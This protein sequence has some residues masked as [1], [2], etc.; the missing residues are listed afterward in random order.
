MSSLTV[1]L[2]GNL[3]SN[4]TEERV[5]TIIGTLTSMPIKSIRIGEDSY[6]QRNVCTLELHSVYEATQ[7]FNIISSMTSGFVIDDAVVSLT[8]GQRIDHSS[9][10][11]TSF[12]SQN[13]AMAAL[14]AAQW[15][16]LDDSSDKSKELP[17]KAALGTVSVNG[18]EYTKYANPDYTSLQ[19]DATSGYYYDPS[20]SFYYDSNS[21]YFYNSVSIL[22]YLLLAASLIHWYFFLK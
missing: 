20:T 6:S 9:V 19:Y 11:A 4:T 10:T 16:N 21:R 7:L 14:A 15:K 17:A 22:L 2:L 5:L 3:A 18:V 1:L 8:Y 12:A 13:A